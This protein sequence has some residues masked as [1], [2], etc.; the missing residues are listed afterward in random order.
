MSRWQQRWSD[1]F[2]DRSKG[3]VDGT[4]EFHQLCAS[5]VRPGSRVLE[6]GAGASNPSSRFFATLGELHGVDMDSAVKENDALKSAAVI[7][8][9]SLPYPDGSFDACVSNYVLEH[10]VDPAGHLREA[11]R[12]L[13]PAGAYVFRTPNRWHYVGMVSS[14]TPHWFHELVANRLANA[15]AHAHEKFPTMYRMNSRAAVRRHAAAAGFVV[16]ELR[17][18]EKDPSY[19]MASR[20]LFLTFMIYERAVNTTELLAGM[21]ANILA[22]LRKPATAQAQE[23]QAEAATGSVAR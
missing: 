8:G 18:I 1:R 5:V 17:M 19:G 15:P 11:W 22:V 9:E 20:V 10:V 13:K 6:I 23:P 12:V 4:T 21:R 2:Y 3:W 14:L 16:E 7:T